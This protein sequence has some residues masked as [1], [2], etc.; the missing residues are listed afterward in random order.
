MTLL[1]KWDV[2][3]RSGRNFSVNSDQNPPS[4]NRSFAIALCLPVP[5]SFAMAGIFEAPR[6]A[7]TLCT[8]AVSSIC[9]PSELTHAAHSPRGS[10][11][12]RSRCSR[13][14]WYVWRHPSSNGV[15]LTHT[16]QFS[17]HKLSP[18]SLKAPLDLPDWTK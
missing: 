16:I 12:H 13:A 5:L 1:Q 15:I 14:E 4:S 10:E 18:L 8:L 3:H 6:N 17:L 2:L 7:D 9:T 11:N